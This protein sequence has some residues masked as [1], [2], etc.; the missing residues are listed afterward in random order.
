MWIKADGEIEV[1]NQNGS[2]VLEADGN[3]T[4]S[5]D[6]TVGGKIDASGEV[7]AQAGGAQSVSLSTHTHPSGT[8]PTGAPTPG[9]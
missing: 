9:T 4:A 8:G 6:L 3:V 5:G 1:S 2:L 7:T